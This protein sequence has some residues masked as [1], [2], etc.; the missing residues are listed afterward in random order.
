[1][2][3]WYTLGTQTAVHHQSEWS[4]FF[5]KAKITDIHVHTRACT[6]IIL[7]T[8]AL[9]YSMCIIIY[10]NHQA[11]MYKVLNFQAPWGGGGVYG[12]QMLMLCEST[13]GQPIAF[14]SFLHSDSVYR[15]NGL[16]CGDIQTDLR[17]FVFLVNSFSSKRVKIRL[18]VQTDKH[19]RVY[20]AHTEYMQLVNQNMLYSL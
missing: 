3:D 14:Q 2:Y 4:F 16:D 6:H 1:M 8:L 18:H 15:R 10:S 5:L 20:W 12:I 7:Y 13:S 11:V 9:T 19:C 17:A